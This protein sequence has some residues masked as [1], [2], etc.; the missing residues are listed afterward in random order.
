MLKRVP[1]QRV[2]LKRTPAK[3]KRKSAK[4]K[5]LI[6]NS[7]DL[8]YKFFLTIW[9][10]REHKSEVSGIPIYGEIKSVYFHHIL[11]K[12]VKKYKEAEFDEENIIILTFDEHTQVESKTFFFEEINKRREKLLK[13]YGFTI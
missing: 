2:P 1:L 12:N 5:L 10:K 7:Y 6:D 13:K 3:L 4:A 11:P 8:Q 9:N